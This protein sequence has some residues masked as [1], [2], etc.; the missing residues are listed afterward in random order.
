MALT[1][2]KLTDKLYHRHTGHPGGIKTRSA[3]QI[4]AGKKPEDLIVLAVQ[5]MLPRNT[6]ART[7]LTNLKVYA[8]AEHP[9][10]AQQPEPL[11]IG[12]MNSKNKRS[13]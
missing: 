2:R 4:L 8:G 6:L 5:R 10:G 12:A 11:D 7:Q 3:G 13:A 1:G 9:H